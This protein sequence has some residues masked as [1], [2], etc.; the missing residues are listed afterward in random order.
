MDKKNITNYRDKLNQNVLK[1]MLF[2]RLPILKNLGIKF[3]EPS[4]NKLLLNNIYEKIDFN[5]QDDKKVLLLEKN[6]KLDMY[7]N[8]IMKFKQEIFQIQ[9]SVECIIFIEFKELYP[10]VIDGNIVFEYLDVFFEI[11]GFKEGN[12]DFIF[13]SKDL[14]YGI[15]IEK[16]EYF[17]KLIKW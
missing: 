13:T 14:S 4:G 2:K 17:N 15:C 16:Y 1:N 7:Y 12:S 10:I 11:S 5:S 8:E 3:M 6:E 9:D